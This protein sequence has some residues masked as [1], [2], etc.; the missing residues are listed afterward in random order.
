MLG[1]R[2]N[3]HREDPQASASRQAVVAE[4]AQRA[5]EGMALD[6]LRKVAAAGIAREL[7]VEQV[8]LL[9]LT[10]D[11]RGLLARAGVGLPGGVLGGVLPAGPGDPPG[12]SALG[13]DLRAS[14]SCHV[15]IETRARR[16]GWIEVHSR[17]ARDFTAEEDGF[18]R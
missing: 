3:R 7:G 18:L 8:A 4:L 14:S 16:S 15:P 13:H 5:L 10:R 11:G 1:R 2:A 9:E 6:E 17:A 12:P